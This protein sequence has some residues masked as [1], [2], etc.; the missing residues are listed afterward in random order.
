MHLQS[1]AKMLPYVFVTNKCNYSRWLPVYLMDM[2]TI[3]DGLKH[4]FD[5]GKFAVHLVEGKFN[6]TYTDLAVE[7]TIVRES[8]GNGGIIGLTRKTPALV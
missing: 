7:K 4:E 2:L 8:K 3:P 1:L 6:G 5:V